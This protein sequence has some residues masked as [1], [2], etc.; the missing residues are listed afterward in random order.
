MADST[1]DNWARGLLVMYV[2]VGEVQ[3]G[4]ED[5]R[6]RCAR[7]IRRACQQ[8]LQAQYMVKKIATI[9]LMSHVTL[10]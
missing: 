2:G 1:E 8:G 6:G 4:V 5:L 3:N 7:V 9:V 10:H